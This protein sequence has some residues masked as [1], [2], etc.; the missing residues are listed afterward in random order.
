M[1]KLLIAAFFVLCA[2]P[3]AAQTQ[4]E[5]AYIEGNDFGFSFYTG[6]VLYEPMDYNM[7]RSFGINLI[8]HPV[9]VI[10]IEPAFF[11]TRIEQDEESNISGS[12]DSD[13]STVAGGS[14]GVFLY[15]HLGGNLYL[16]VGPRASYMNEDVTSYNNENSSRTERKGDYW[17]I[18]AVFGMKFM[19]NDHF[20]VFGDFGFGYL[21]HEY[22]YR[23]FN[24]S[25]TKTTDRTTKEK[26]FTAA[27][28]ILGVTFYL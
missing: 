12:V 5:R 26:F 2:I 3:L 24:S 4:A 22:D 16:Y 20:A 28:A 25:G 17:G 10:A 13:R 9:S 19:F 8:Y 18:S 14:I 21:Q 6:F 15:N 1:K 23:Y 27:S 11:F 7:T